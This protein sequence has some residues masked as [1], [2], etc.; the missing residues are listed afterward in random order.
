VVAVAA[1]AGGILA[2]SE[3]LGAL[4]ADFPVPVLVVQHLAPHHDSIIAEVLNHRTALLVKLAEDGER[5]VTGVVYVAPPNHHLRVTEG[6]RVQLGVG[7]RVHFVRP[8]ADLLFESVAKAYGPRAL[9]CVLS[10][11]GQDGAQG[12]GLV[13]AGGGTVIVEDPESAQFKGMPEAAVRACAVDRVLPLSEIGP[14]LRRL[15]GTP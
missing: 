3:V 9:V 12:A 11:T 5:I 13:K 1:S 7:E 8:A 14:A 2:L 15:T 4:P 6:G 10:G